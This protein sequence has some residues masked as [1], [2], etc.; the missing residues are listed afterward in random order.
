[1]MSSPGDK[2][3]ASYADDRGRL[4]KAAQNTEHPDSS[5]TA[6][7]HMSQYTYHLPEHA[8]AQHPL[9]ERDASRLLVWGGKGLVAHSQFRDLPVHIGQ[10][11]S[12]ACLVLNETLVLPAR[13]LLRKPTGG[14]V[15]VL[16]NEPRTSAVGPQ[17]VLATGDASEWHA[18]IG[19]RNVHPGM[20]L[21]DP[22][23]LLRV[24]V[25]SRD[26]M[27]GTVR[28]T[29]ET[30]ESLDSILRR[31]GHVPLPPYI[32]RPD[33]ADDQHRYQTVFARHGGSVAAPTA[34]LHFTSELLD[35]IT[36][37]GHRLARV[38]LHV[39]MGTFKPVEAQDAREHLMHQ[40]RIELGLDTV[41]RISDELHAQAPY[42]IPV[43]TTSM[44]TLESVHWLGALLLSGALQ[45]DVSVPHI[46]QFV[47]FN[48]ELAHYTARQT[49]RAVQE[50][51]R[52][53]GRLTLVAET[54][55]MLAPGAHIRV[56]DALIT[57]F[58][59]PGST[60]LLLVAA[61]LGGGW[62][63]AYQEALNGGY[64]FLS[65]GDAMLITRTHDGETQTA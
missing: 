42:I 56:T 61:L 6:P 46:P 25:L 15:E 29:S 51:M 47:A 39:G 37:A 12:H 21:L 36:A 60:L 5:G 38:T 58:H 18:I 14:E 19:G 41:E 63:Q 53:T 10:L 35:R 9:A 57:N 55:L 22:Q 13:L 32:N 27:E 54:Q 33:D 43:G 26:R 4:Q 62:R 31:I 30:G 45:E 11:S 20:V 2:V 24:E 17:Q 59:Q 50:W 44:R 28:L 23:G 65:Y 49:W 8:I 16:L 64:R 1:M 52:R 40:E 7:L 34:G 48:V 3:G